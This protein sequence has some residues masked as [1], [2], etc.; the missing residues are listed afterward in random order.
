MKRL[1]T[2][3]ISL[4]SSL[5]SFAQFTGRVSDSQGVEYTANNDETTC[6]VSRYYE[7]KSSINI[8]EVYKGRRVT[9]IG[10]YAFSGCSGLTSITIPSSVT[11]IGDYAFWECSGLTSITIPSSVTW[12][13]RGA[14]D[15][16]SGL[17]SI[18]IP[19]SVTWIGSG[20]FDSC[21]FTLVTIPSSVISIFRDAFH[22]CSGLTSIRVTDEIPIPLD[23]HNNPF[24]YSFAQSVTLYV[25]IGSKELYEAADVW[26]YFIEIKEWF[27]I[28]CGSISDLQGIQYTANDDETTCYVSGHDEKYSSEIVIPKYFAGRQITSIKEGAF[29][30][31]SDINS[32]SIGLE[33]PLA[34]DGSVFGGLNYQSATLYV[35]KGYIDAYREAN[36]WNNFGDMKEL[37]DKSDGELSDSQ[38][39]K[40]TAN[41]DETTCYVS[42]RERNYSTTITIPEV[43][44]GRRV[45]SIGQGA[46]SWCRASS[47]TIPS[48]VTSISDRAF[49]DCSG[50]TSVAI[51]SS[52][53]SIGGGAFDGCSGL[54]SITIPSSVKSISNG[55]LSG[56]SSIIV[57][58]G[59]PAYDSRE[60][61]NAIIRT[62]D[63]KLIAGCKNTIIPSSVTSIG[64]E[65]FSGCSGL[66]SVTIPSSV[67]SI[68]DHAFRDCI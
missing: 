47:I 65:A 5:L 52:V 4:L 28:S 6:Y 12:I 14:F 22:G 33:E 60:N 25:P 43:F 51:P 8:P 20:A 21:S 3:C 10:L 41:N 1:L 68:G 67:T 46:F 26:K 37:F 40:Y 29:A 54:T 19:S 44:R 2:I 13:G 63:N 57:E 38:G 7:E 16:C 55:G 17:T 62:S 36:V 49:Y 45:T 32:I 11:S 18:T 35:P 42:D 48:S 59:N 30:G 9:S 64:D 66:T 53:I 23:I 15:S 24:S 58:E 50:L 27:D 31:C 39:V 61:C 56:L 34:I